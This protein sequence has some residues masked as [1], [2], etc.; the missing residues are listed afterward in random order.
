MARKPRLLKK[1]ASYHVYAQINRQEYYLQEL[2][3]KE[4]FKNVLK[5]AKKKY[6]FSIRNFCIMGNHFHLDITPGDKGSLSRIMQWIMSMFARR[7]NALVNQIGRVWRGRFKSKIIDSINYALRLFVYISNNPVRAGLVKT[8]ERYK[9]NGLF[10]IINNNYSILDP[11]KGE[12]K[13]FTNELLIKHEN[14]N[15][16]LIK[17]SIKIDQELGFYPQKPGRK[18]KEKNK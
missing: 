4:I 7:Y 12:F 2:D 14:T 3:V 18:K 15:E 9:Y 6:S 17:K 8:A 10:D 5:Q 1:E 13:S 16:P 11:P